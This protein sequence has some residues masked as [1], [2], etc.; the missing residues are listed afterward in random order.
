MS[1]RLLLPGEGDSNPIGNLWT[2]GTPATGCS[3]AT[4]APVEA[5]R[6]YLRGYAAENRFN[7]LYEVPDLASMKSVVPVRFWKDIMQHNGSATA[8]AG[9][10]VPRNDALGRMMLSFV[11]SPQHPGIRAAGQPNCTWRQERG[12]AFRPRRPAIAAPANTGRR[13]AI[14]KRVEMA[15][16]SAA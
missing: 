7:W 12:V 3:V 6:V 4:G 14:L 8:I 16:S 11:T 13:Q 15:T 10:G 5:R 2:R 1:S 9:Q